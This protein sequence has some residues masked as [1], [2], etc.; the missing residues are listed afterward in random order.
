MSDVMPDAA[1][2]ATRPSGS[3]RRFRFGVNLTSTAS[4]SEWIEKCRRA[5]ALGFDVL[6]LPDHLGAMSPFPALVAAAEATERPRVGTFVL[7]AGFWNPVLLARDVATADQLTGGRLEVGLG[8]GYVRAEFDAAGLPWESAGQRIARLERTI[9]A[10]DKLLPDAGHRPRPAQQP[11]VPM[12]VGGHGDRL[13]RMAAARADIVGFTGAVQPRGMP[14]GTLNL[15][16]MATLTERV[17]F[18]RAAAGDR[19]DDIEYNVLVQVAMLTDDRRAT[20]EQLRQSYA[21]HLP[22][23]QLLSVDQI[24]EIPTMLVGTAEEI[25]EQLRKHRAELGVSYFCVLEPWMDAMGPVIELLR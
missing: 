21:K 4:R 3:P 20:V 24:L 12:L 11:R 6:L 17:Q 15:V 8:T 23:D 22:D 13:L 16:D 5:E 7:N 10:L 19:A 1:A 9:E 25:A 18:A 14:P 2:P